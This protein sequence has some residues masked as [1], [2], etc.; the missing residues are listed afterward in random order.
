MLETPSLAPVGLFVSAGDLD[1]DGKFDILAGWFDGT[2]WQGGVF[3]L[4]EDGKANLAKQLPTVTGAS[5]SPRVGLSDYNKDGKLDLIFA[6]G[7]G[8]LGKFSYYDFDTMSELTSVDA[9]NIDPFSNFVAT[10][11]SRVKI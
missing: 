2:N 1:N 5:G 8:G 9:N 3:L 7:A 11:F 10:N 4:E 6:P